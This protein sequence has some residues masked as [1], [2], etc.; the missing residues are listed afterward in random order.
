MSIFKTTK[1]LCLRR[2]LGMKYLVELQFGFLKL[3][4]CYFI[5]Q[6]KYSV[7]RSVLYQKPMYQRTKSGIN[8]HPREGNSYCVWKTGMILYIRKIVLI[9]PF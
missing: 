1:L 7:I 5:T 3:T 8:K 2:N 9:K 4:L 6:M